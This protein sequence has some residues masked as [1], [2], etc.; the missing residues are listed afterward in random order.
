MLEY[1]SSAAIPI[2]ILLIF[3]YGIIK[4]VDMYEAFV[5]GAKKGISTTLGMRGYRTGQTG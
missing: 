5:S 1:I 4:Q 3:T 2:I